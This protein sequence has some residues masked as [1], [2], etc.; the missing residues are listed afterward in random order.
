ME[1]SQQLATIIIPAYNEETGIGPLLQKMI[2]N[3]LH[4]KYE[5]IVVD[6][7]SNDRT[8][9]IVKQYPVRLILH[10]TNKGYGAALKTGIRKALCNKVIMLDSDGQH[11]PSYIDIV[12]NML[13][14][15]DMV[16]GERDSTSHQVSSRKSGKWII[17]KTGEMLVDQKLPD[18]NS[19]MR[20]FQRDLILNLLHLMPNG[21]SFST[22]S[23]LSFL[24]EGYSIGTF[25]INVVE[26]VGRSSNVRFIKDGS[27]TFLLLFRIIMLFNPLKVFFPASLLFTFGGLVWGVNGYFFFGRFPNTGMIL[28]TLGMFMFFFGLLA[29]Q[30]AILNRKKG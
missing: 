1:N 7:G 23:T 28:I 17:R 16:I 8:A 29:D 20:G 24:K 12:Y 11:D 3:N 14:D 9:E 26:R 10:G 22:T 15:Y 27:K 6:D 25:P 18:Y 30:I 5:I 21:F 19:G 4:Q 13:A 2:S